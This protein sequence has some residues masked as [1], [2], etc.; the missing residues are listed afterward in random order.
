MWRFEHLEQ[1]EQRANPFVDR[2]T[3]RKADA[4]DPT[5]GVSFDCP[6]QPL[7]LVAVEADRVK[8]ARSLQLL[9]QWEVERNDRLSRF[10]IKIGEIE[11]PFGPAQRD[12]DIAEARLGVHALGVHVP[13]CRIFYG[14][15]VAVLELVPELDPVIRD[16]LLGLVMLDRDGELAWSVAGPQMPIGIEA[17]PD[18]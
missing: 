4:V 9:R 16:L 1:I 13:M 12:Q 18:G 17:F 8:S 7:R 3:G 10:V 14:D 15:R 2:L 5:V 11:N 6:E